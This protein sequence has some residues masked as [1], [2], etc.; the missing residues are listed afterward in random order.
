MIAIGI[1]YGTTNSLMTVYQA[2]M[3]SRNVKRVMKE[4][5]YND[6]KVYI[7]SPKRL[8]NDVHGMDKSKMTR[9]IASCVKVLCGK[10]A[11]MSVDF[12]DVV[13]TI[14]VPN[15]FKDHQ[16]TFL[17][18]AVVN[19]L[20]QSTGKDM[21]QDSVHVL[22][23]PVAAALYYA[24][25]LRKSGAGNITRYVIVSDMGGGTTD[26]AAVRVDIEPNLLRFNVV[27]TEH[28]AHL[29]GDDIDMGIMDHLR[30]N[31]EL[32]NASD[33]VLLPFCRH[34]K[35][36]LSVEDVVSHYILSDEVNGGEMEVKMTRSQLD[37]IISNYNYYCGKRF[38]DVYMRMLTRLKTSLS[39]V[40]SKTGMAFDTF[41]NDNCI[42]L[43]V[44]GSSKIPLLRKAFRDTFQNS[45]IFNMVTEDGKTDAQVSKYDS[46]SRGAAIHSAYQAKLITGFTGMIVV[47]NRTMHK[48]TINYAGDRLT[49]CVSKS[50]PDGD[51][52]VKVFRP[53]YLSFDGSTFTLQK[54]DFYQGGYDDVM[55]ED[56]QLMTSVVLEDKIYTNGRK[57][58]EIE[59]VLRFVISQGRLVKI[60]VFVE[61]GCKD[62]SDFHKEVHLL[63]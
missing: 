19:A 13:F 26:L 58:E 14:T 22:P 59:V 46:V 61:R 34:L 21:K 18:E 23:E 32:S 38:L 33:A 30:G 28:D 25:N 8:L 40:V 29:G 47:E 24:Y 5:S 45:C 4:S 51:D 63:G 57:L 16:C 37:D 60:K 35:E 6:G 36:R 48:I 11:E 7:R 62:N 15:A 27:C 53:K 50:M 3:T 55:D 10:L 12:S 31:Y 54:L 44:G 2:D 9:Y 41:L 42:L 52:Y 1:D 56:T 43:P 39:E 20:K 49:T 17:K